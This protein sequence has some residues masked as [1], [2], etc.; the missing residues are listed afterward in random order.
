MI[1]SPPDGI[2]EAWATIS[3]HR[4]RYLTGGSGRPL[5]LIHGLL[6]YSF[7]W[8]FNLAEFAKHST[9][10]AIDLLGVGFSDRPVLDCSL[11]ATAKRL[12]TFL[13]QLGVKE[14]DLLGT[15][16]GGAVALRLAALD[17]A[18][19]RR[20]VLAAPAN[21]WSKSR[22]WA[23]RLFNTAPA[24]ALAPWLFGKTLV[25]H[26]QIRRMYGD[27]GRIT[28]GTLAGYSE[29]LHTPGTIPHALRI[30][31]CWRQDMDELRGLM[32]AISA[33]PTLLLWGDRDIPVSIASANA[34][35]QH[36]N[37]A[38]LV[39]FPG[40]GHLPYEEVPEAFNRAVT[41]F[42]TR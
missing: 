8:R 3:G 33:I 1:P 22:M 21:P 6:G 13:D 31:S 7:S 24:R 29:P 37:R 35:K 2:R 28:P 19:V 23:V 38:E 42:L 25:H 26:L 39:V 14:F 32:P 9:V 5:L 30:V 12:R 40:V 16:H 34:V 41:E 4:M 10:F 17:A 11:R 15:S 20:L 27:P 36:F 18:R